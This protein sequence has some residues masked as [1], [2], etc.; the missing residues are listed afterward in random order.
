M[1]YAREA[2]PEA[3]PLPEPEAGQ[4]KYVIRSSLSSFLFLLF[5]L[6]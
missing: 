4:P 2:E 3:E 5:A 6:Y 1:V